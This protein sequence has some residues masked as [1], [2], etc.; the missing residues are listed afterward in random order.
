MNADAV[1][2]LCSVLETTDKEQAQAALTDGVGY[3]C[4]GVA[5]VI[6]PT[7]DNERRRVFLG[8]DPWP[9]NNDIHS[10]KLAPVEVM[11]WLGLPH[12]DRHRMGEDEPDFDYREYDPRLEFPHD[13]YGAR[14]LVWAQAVYDSGVDPGDY[15]S[16]EDEVSLAGLNDSGLTFKQIAQMIRYFGLA[17]EGE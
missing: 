9:S 12:E 10:G 15:P 4:L 11:E 14:V 17:G 8:L 2:T 6:C 16:V 1:E 13:Y 5:T 3:C 7:M